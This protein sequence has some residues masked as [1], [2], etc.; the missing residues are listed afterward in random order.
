[1]QQIHKQI[2]QDVYAWA[3][4]LRTVDMV[5]GKPGERTLFAFTDEIPK[6]AEV[7]HGI[8]WA[9][10]YGRGQDKQAFVGMMTAVHAELNRIH[11]FR[12][13]N[14]RATREYMSELANVSGHRLDYSKV[15]K[16]IWDE[17]TKQSARANTA[18]M[19]DV[20]YEITSVDRAVA[21]DKLEPTEALARHPELDG[22]YK[23]LMNA[24][25]AGLEE[26]PVRTKIL[27]ELQAS[28]IV[29][30]DVTLEESR[31]VIG[32]AAAYRGLLVRNP[33]E[34]GG[35]VRGDI[36]AISSHHALVKMNDRVAVRYE[37]NDLDRVVDVGRKLTIQR[38]GERRQVFDQGKEPARNRG[39]KEI[40]IE[41]EIGER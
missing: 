41:R 26:A 19:R 2:F 20:L 23:A 4:D 21:F 33:A 24:T 28:R 30:S 13:G 35:T 32:H 29:S 14:G 9:A 27:R 34:V 3:G 11:P 37:R 31:L 22:A 5:K 38:A 10:D 18:P 12:E 17:A 36:V 15:S 8:V 7:A 25:E 6:W 39:G 16:E 1:L 40:Q